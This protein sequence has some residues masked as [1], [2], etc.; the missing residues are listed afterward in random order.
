MFDIISASDAKGKSNRGRKKVLKTSLVRSISL[1][2]AGSFIMQPKSLFRAASN[3][4]S[5]HK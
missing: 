1:E 4:P 2:A 5:T 3:H